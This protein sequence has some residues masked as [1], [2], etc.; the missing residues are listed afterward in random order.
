MYCNTKRLWFCFLKK[1]NANNHTVCGFERVQGKSRERGVQKEGDKITPNNQKMSVLPKCI[2]TPSFIDDDKYAQPAPPQG[3]KGYQMRKM[4]P[5]VVLALQRESLLQIHAE[6]DSVDGR[7]AILLYNVIAFQE[8]FDARLKPIIAG[9][10]RYGNVCRAM[11]LLC[12]M[13]PQDVDRHLLSLLE[14][15]VLFVRK[16]KRLTPYPFFDDVLLVEGTKQR[17]KESDDSASGE[18]QAN[19]S[20]GDEPASDLALP[21][22]IVLPDYLKDKGFCQPPLPVGKKAW[23]RSKL[24]AHS[25]RHA[26]AEEEL[27]KIHA[28]FDS[29]DG[30]QRLTVLSIVAFGKNFVPLDCIQANQVYYGTLCRAAQLH[31][32]AKVDVDRH[33]KELLERGIVHV[34]TDSRG[35]RTLSASCFLET[36]QMATAKVSKTSDAQEELLLDPTAKIAT[37][38]FVLDARYRSSEAPGNAARWS[39]ADNIGHDVLGSLSDA[40]LREIHSEYDST[41]QGKERIQL[42]NVIAFGALYMEQQHVQLRQ[43]QGNNITYGQLCRAAIALGIAQASLDEHLK[44]MLER[45]V[46]TTRYYEPDNSVT[47]RAFPFLSFARLAPQDERLQNYKKLHSKAFGKIAV[48]RKTQ[49]AWSSVESARVAHKKRKRSQLVEK[50]KA[51]ATNVPI[52]S[53]QNCVG[54]RGNACTFGDNGQPRCVSPDNW[55]LHFGVETR[56]PGVLTRRKFCDDCIGAHRVRPVVNYFNIQKRHTDLTLQAMVSTDIAILGVYSHE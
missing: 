52:G 25:A 24:M 32:I 44:A 2:K 47:L 43:L 6:P 11:H 8:R 55:F 27:R 28:E 46:V 19:D 18:E 40:S 48:A 5:D 56:Q 42:F 26:F 9:K 30:K 50:R 1:G 3:R 33:L 7:Q 31:S 4:E 23:R 29:E 39:R 36:V 41:E 51:A 16:D 22:R 17:R 21:R 15:K 13:M 38:E 45:K 20:I 34:V 35:D 12:G 49:Q 37:P 14:K 10:S 53:E 54:Y